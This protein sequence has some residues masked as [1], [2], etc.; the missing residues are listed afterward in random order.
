VVLHH[1]RDQFADFPAPFQTAAGQT[2]VDLFFVN[3]GCVMV[4]V[5]SSRDRSPRQFLQ[6]RTVNRS[7]LLVL[8]PR[9]LRT[10]V[11]RAAAVQGEASVSKVIASAD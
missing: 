4:F 5:M 8:H 1:A 7:N 11:D 9:V 10:V 3:S 2:G 6:A